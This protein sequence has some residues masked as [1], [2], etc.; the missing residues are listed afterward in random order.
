MRGQELKEEPH[1]SRQQMKRKQ[2]VW[3]VLKRS[4]RR[5]MRGHGARCAACRQKPSKV[6]RQK[7]RS[8]QEQ[9]HMLYS[10]HISL[11]LW[12]WEFPLYFFFF[13]FAKI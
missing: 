10:R 9:C 5:E 2:H 1:L 7:V 13:F 8:E 11:S 6:C 12:L 4:T 3:V